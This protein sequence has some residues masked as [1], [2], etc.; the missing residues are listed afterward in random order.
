M[1]KV[2]VANTNVDHLEV[3]FVIADFGTRDGELYPPAD[4][5][6]LSDPLADAG[7][8]NLG[9]EAD[10]APEGRSGGDLFE[11][12]RERFA[13][14]LGWLGSEEARELEHSALESRIES[15]GRE[16]LCALVQDHLDLRAERERR[17]ERVEDEQGVERRAVERGHD[18]PLQT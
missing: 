9:F 1:P 16:L 5:V 12:S 10:Q 8:T 6:L 11:R 3:A 15:D 4:E 18:R 14:I 7:A 17:L 13:L 2:G